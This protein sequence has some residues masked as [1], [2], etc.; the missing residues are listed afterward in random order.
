MAV[1]ILQSEIGAPGVYAPQKRNHGTS[2][3]AWVVLM[4]QIGLSNQAGTGPEL[5]FSFPSGM[6]HQVH[7]H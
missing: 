3:E 2:G 7:L 1:E 5:S 6:V 4:V